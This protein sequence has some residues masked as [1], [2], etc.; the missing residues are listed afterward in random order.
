MNEKFAKWVQF[1]LKEKQISQA[2]L[3][4]RANVTPTAISDILSGRR[5]V[6]HKVAGAISSALG[7]PP[8]FGL[9]QA[10]HLPPITE[11]EEDE[12]L[13]NYLYNNLKTPAAKK[14][15]RDYLKF[16]SS[17]EEQGEFTENAQDS[18]SAKK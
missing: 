16:I 8:E 6:G 9:R 2:E 5:G 13:I 4:R 11:A 10:G 3:A 12:E 15:A 14:Q 7:Y 17:Q 1:E 18:T